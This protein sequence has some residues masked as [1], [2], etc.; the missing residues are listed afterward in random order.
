MVPG[1]IDCETEKLGRELYLKS[2]GHTLAITVTD[3]IRKGEV[4]K[5]R[6]D[7]RQEL[8]VGKR[9]SHLSLFMAGIRS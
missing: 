7:S 6:T 8:A 1:Q 5:G 9:V 2:K 4:L 3:S